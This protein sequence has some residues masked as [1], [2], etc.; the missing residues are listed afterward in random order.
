[1]LFGKHIKGAFP[2]PSISQA[3][4]WRLA[5]IRA[6]VIITEDLLPARSKLTD[7]WPFIRDLDRSPELHCNLSRI[8]RTELVLT[9]KPSSKK[10][11]EARSIRQQ[12]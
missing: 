2:N 7:T 12:R 9:D 4:K 10:L 6:C 1:M 8:E 3:V 5:Q 11:G